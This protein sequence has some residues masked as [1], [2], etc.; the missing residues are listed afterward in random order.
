VRYLYC[1]IFV[2]L[3]AY[4]IGGNLGTPKEAYDKGFYVGWCTSQFV[5][6]DLPVVASQAVCQCVYKLL[7]REHPKGIEHA[8]G[9]EHEK[10]VMVCSFSYFSSE[11]NKTALLEKKEV[12]EVKEVKVKKAKK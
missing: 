3:F 7:I 2:S 9:E 12:K 10:A 4:A 8:S 5:M 6:K 1:F 11:E